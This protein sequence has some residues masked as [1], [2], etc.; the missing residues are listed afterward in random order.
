M[1]RPSIDLWVLLWVIVFPV[2]VVLLIAIG[3]IV[4]AF[5]AA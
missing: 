4:R 5:N 2:A 3:M 1:K